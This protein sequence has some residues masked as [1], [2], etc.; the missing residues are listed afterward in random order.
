[1][2][3]CLSSKETRLQGDALKP[4]FSKSKTEIPKQ[5]GMTKNESPTPVFM[6]NSFQHLVILKMFYVKITLPHFE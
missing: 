3:N 5:F 6:L 2:L 1:M 4:K